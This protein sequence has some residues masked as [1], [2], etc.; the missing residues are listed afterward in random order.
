MRIALCLHISLTYGGGGEKWAWNVAKYLSRKGH[1]VEI[2]ALPYTP[3][4][5]RAVSL[6]ELAEI[7]DGIPYHEGWN[8]TVRSDISY[9][10]YNPLG[11]VFFHCES[12][13]IAGIHSNVYFMPR[14]PPLTYGLPA[15]FSRLL[16]KV[17][18]VADL[19]MY[20]AIHVMNKALKVRH[21]KIYYIPNF[22]DTDVYKPMTSKSDKFTVLY[23][24]RPLW[25]KGWDVFLTVANVLRSKYNDTEFIWVGG[26]NDKM[27][28][29]RGL[30][31][32]TNEQELASLYSSAH[33]TVYPSRADNFP[34]VI[35]E[36]LACGTPV[37]TTRIPAHLSLD[38]PLLYANDVNEFSQKVVNL[39]KE[40]KKDP[41]HVLSPSIRLRE[42]A[43]EYDSKNVL[44]IFERMLIENC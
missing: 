25:Q 41:N 27:S 1:Q 13:K 12:K 26:T 24:G 29:V 43:M 6:N 35:V 19:S 4:G 16:Y 21:R 14:T 33:V 23:V 20:E 28:S 37:L 42:A 15:I 32:V 38:L 40:W 22:V 18:G 39:Y 5:K 17:M 11:Y 44:P 7:L 3:H 36:S 10:F 30:G 9:M 34:L 2:C 31:Y 8:H